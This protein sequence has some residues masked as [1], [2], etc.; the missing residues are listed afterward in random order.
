MGGGEQKT[1]SLL[2]NRSQTMHQL[3]AYVHRILDRYSFARFPSFFLQSTNPVRLPLLHL[4]L[5]FTLRFSIRFSWLF[6]FKLFF[7]S[8]SQVSKVFSFILSFLA[9]ILAL[10]HGDRFREQKKKVSSIAA[11]PVRVNPS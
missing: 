6:L 9:I 7:S 5:S 4:L 2:R 3:D 11:L 1:N 8:F 10:S